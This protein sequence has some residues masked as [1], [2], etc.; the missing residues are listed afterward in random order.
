MSDKT[1]I[2]VI[3]GIIAVAGLLLSMILGAVAGGVAGYF[4]GREQ[5]RTV[6]RD[7]WNAWS[8]QMPQQGAAP[9]ATPA[10]E[11]TP[12]TPPRVEIPTF[13]ALLTKVTPDTPADRAGLRA[14]DIIVAVDDERVTLAR[15]LAEII[16]KYK[17]GD[18]VRITYRREGEEK[19]VRVTLGQHPDDPNRP[20]LGITYTSAFQPMATP[21]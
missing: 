6:A 10:P 16:R 20:Y 13:G 5:A 3:V 19:T 2:Y 7:E 1:R 9:T 12:F 14:G 17:P 11:R 21:R 18:E 15:D 4:V 8:R